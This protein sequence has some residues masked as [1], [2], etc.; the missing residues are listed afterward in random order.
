MT[1]KGCISILSHILSDTCQRLRPSA[2]VF[3]SQT[4]TE[5]VA[6][7][8]RRIACTVSHDSSR[9]KSCSNATTISV[10][11][12]TRPPARI[13]SLWSELPLHLYPPFTLIHVLHLFALAQAKSTRS[14]P[15]V[16]FEIIHHLLTGSPGS[17]K[18]VHCSFNITRPAFAS[19]HPSCK[20]FHSSSSSKMPISTPLTKMLG[21]RV[22]VSLLVRCSGIQY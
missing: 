3:R 18:L 15:P 1:T 14:R 16:R 5:P 8:A 9:S 17:R 19:L 10:W 7:G 13:A 21:I 4:R 12:S 20:S 2:I 11:L 6:R 22:C